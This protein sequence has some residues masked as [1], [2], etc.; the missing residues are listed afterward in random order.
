MQGDLN[1]LRNTN[2]P[3]SKKLSLSISSFNKGLSLK[4]DK[5]LSNI[6]YASEIENFSFDSGALTDGIGFDNVFNNIAKPAEIQ[7]L[8]SDLQNVGN[9]EK[10]IYFYKF[11]SKTQTRQDKLLF[12]S[13]TFEVYFVNLYDTQKQL[14]K[15]RNVKFTSSPVAISYR[16]N[17]EDVIIFSSETDNMTVWDGEKNPY[18]VLDSPHISSMTV[19]FERLFATVDGEKNS[20]WFSDELDPTEWS[21]SLDEA[22]F[23]EMIDERGALLKVVSFLDYV[24]IFREFGISKL[25][26]FGN[27]STFSCS[28]LYVSSGR[29]NPE[30]VCVC[31]D[32]ILFLA[33]DGIYKFDGVDTVK[34]LTNIEDGF[35]GLNNNNAVACFSG[36][37]YFLACNFLCESNYLN[38]LLE[39]DTTSFSLKNIVKGYDFKFI[40]AIKSTDF[41]GVFT[42]VKESS[43]NAF[44]PATI[45][46]NGKYFGIPTKKVWNSQISNIG[47]SFCEKVLKNIYVQT[48]TPIKIVVS[49]NEKEHEFNFSP[50]NTLGMKHCL[51]PVSDFSFKIVCNN[52]SCNIKNLKF[53]FYKLWRNTLW[54]ME[55]VPI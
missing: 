41:E 32:K 18:E 23:I 16:L 38:T 39:I 24:Y 6:E 53:D 27:Q 7:T 2:F 47:D 35:K 17:G 52:S 34:I 11:N 5:N 14:S 4:Y 29:I 51:I 9:I 46:K 30:S 37:S 12:I 31:G 26:A 1:R 44:L 45:V 54:I 25:S 8:S 10:I 28:N 22:G 3:K 13:S 21:I 42:I 55:K 50:S 36:S 33:S 49:S 40:C 15:L 19:H 48:S 20:I 43:K